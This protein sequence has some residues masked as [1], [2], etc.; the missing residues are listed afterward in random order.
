MRTRQP[1]GQANQPPFPGWQRPHLL[2]PS[3]RPALPTWRPHHHFHAAPTRL[4]NTLVIRLCALAV[5]I[6]LGCACERGPWA[7]DA[8]RPPVS[9]QFCKHRG[10]RGGGGEPRLARAPPPPSRSGCAVAPHG[11]GAP[12]GLC[13]V[14][15][16]VAG[17][18]R[19]ASTA[20]GIAFP[21]GTTDYFPE[22]KILSSL[23]SARGVG[24][25]LWR[26]LV[27]IA[28]WRQ[29][30]GR[31]AASKKRRSS[32]R[33]SGPRRDSP[34][35]PLPRDDFDALLCGP[36]GDRRRPVSLILHPLWVAA[37]QDKRYAVC[38]PSSRRLLRRRHQQETAGAAAVGR[39]LLPRGRHRPRPE[40]PGRTS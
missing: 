11:G 12:S 7:A 18:G 9:F 6:W 8:A 31:D 15:A 17:R 22:S 29:G 28:R 21:V 10:E 23:S 3:F 24:T 13:F 4:P 37:R 2:P 39:G 20:G 25:P 16:T 19:R 36:R 26:V 38:N 32:P 27:V 34:S 30:G 35:Q 5:A 40:T 1:Y 33:R 14:P